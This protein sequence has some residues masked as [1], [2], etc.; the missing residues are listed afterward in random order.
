MKMGEFMNKPT[1][2][3]NK[4]DQ[5]KSSVESLLLRSAVTQLLRNGKVTGVE[6]HSYYVIVDKIRL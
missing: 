4:I 2:Y 5:R 1:V 3:F 6:K